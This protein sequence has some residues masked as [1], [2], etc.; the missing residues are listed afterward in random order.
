MQNQKL[1]RDKDGSIK[2]FFE[3]HE[4]FTFHESP[5]DFFFILSRY[6]FAS[7]IL[8]DKKNVID[9]GSGHGFGS[10]LLSK[11]VQ[12]LLAV[13]IDEELVQYCN[14]THTNSNNIKFQKFDLLNYDS[15]YSEIFDGL[16]SL[17]VIEHF[18]KE[19]ILNVVTQ[20]H[21]LL[22]TGGVAVIGTPNIASRPFASER[23]IESHPFEFDYDFFKA[24]LQTKFSNVFIFSMTDE[25]VSTSFSKLAWYFM[26][27]CIK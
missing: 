1:F 22:K 25:T 3:V 7:K 19:N 20:Y 14:K 16:C 17:D 15:K 23:R 18:E 21:N 9:I 11:F 5:L 4:G 27:V 13:D 8:A 10:I 12:N 6:K 26:A 2:S 24:S